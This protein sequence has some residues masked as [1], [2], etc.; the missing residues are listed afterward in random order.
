MGPAVPKHGNHQEM[1]RRKYKNNQVQ[2]NN[3][4]RGYKRQYL[5]LIEG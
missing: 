3:Q 1:K 5:T 2:E 4:L